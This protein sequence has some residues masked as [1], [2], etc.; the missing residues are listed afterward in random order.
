MAGWQSDLCSAI[1]GADDLAA[2]DRQQA[3]APQRLLDM[4]AVTAPYIT[5][6]DV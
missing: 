1:P 3:V 6:L 5:Y 2:I 4:S